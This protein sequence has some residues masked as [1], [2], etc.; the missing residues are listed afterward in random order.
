MEKINIMDEEISSQFL[1]L[2]FI[3]WNS[4]QFDKVNWNNNRHE[5]WKNADSLFKVN[6]WHTSAVLIWDFWGWSQ[7]LSWKN[8]NKTGVWDKKRDPSP[9]LQ[10]KHPFIKNSNNTVIFMSLRAI[11]YERRLK[12]KSAFILQK[13]DPHEMV[14]V[15]SLRTLRESVRRLFTKC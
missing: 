11:Q 2:N 3:F 1:N 5:N 6:F 13:I 15:N 9:W 12:Y 14:L 4:T 7:G 10:G 8:K